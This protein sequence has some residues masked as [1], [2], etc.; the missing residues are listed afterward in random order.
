MRSKKHAESPKIVKLPSDDNEIT[1]VPVISN[2][3]AQPA[4]KKIRQKYKD[5]R[6]N[7]ALKL[8][9]LKGAEVVSVNDDPVSK[10]SAQIAAKNIS[11]KYKKIRSKKMI[12][13]VQ[14]VQEAASEK[15]AQIVAKK[16]SKNYKRMRNK[17]LALPLSLNNLA[18]KESIV[19]NDERNLNGV[20][21]NKNAKIAA[22]KIS[23]KYK[24][25]RAKKNSLP[26]SLEEIEEAYTE[27]YND[28]TNLTDVNLNKNAAIAAKKISD[29]YKKIRG[30]RKR[31][32]PIGPVEGLAKRPRT[33]AGSKKLIMLPAKKVSD[34]YKKL[35]NK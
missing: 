28:N 26:F 29:K 1:G 30:K 31:D 17:R 34:T 10:K 27:N 21:S 2:I 8:L 33:S 25:M 32:M 11:D 19:Y 16:I 23:K 35:R 15:N 13:L 6:R 24:K 9:R 18:E 14:D 7:K 22:S 5:I 12:D 3:S 20:R 4:A